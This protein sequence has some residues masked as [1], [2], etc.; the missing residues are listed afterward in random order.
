MDA[1]DAMEA[2]A[3]QVI[4]KWPRDEAMSAH[5]LNEICTF[6]HKKI[7]WQLIHDKRDFTVN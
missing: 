6:P 3:P 2:K 7:N 5:E 1:Y 4:L